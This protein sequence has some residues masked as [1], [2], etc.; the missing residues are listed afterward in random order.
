[1]VA[2]HRYLQRAPVVARQASFRA[3]RALRAL[4]FFKKER[5]FPL[6]ETSKARKARTFL[7]TDCRV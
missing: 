5:T 4:L 1:M 2:L 6:I 3:L 7:L